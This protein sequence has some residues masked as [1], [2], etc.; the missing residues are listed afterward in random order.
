MTESLPPNTRDS[1][2]PVPDKDSKAPLWRALITIVVLALATV[3]AFSLITTQP[4]EPV[5]APADEFSAARMMQTLDKMA[6][7]G[8]PRPVGS[9][10]NARVRAQ[11]IGEIKA[12]GYKPTI[13]STQLTTQAVFPTKAIPVVVRQDISPLETMNTENIRARAG[14]RSRPRTSAI[15]R[16][17]LRHG[18][19]RSW[20]SRRRPLGRVDG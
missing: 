18:A 20:R 15:D 7:T 11:L 14:H 5:D 1:E 12:L 8:L 9:K 17:P 13:Q 2:D 10:E 19:F 6:A 3:Y 4:P 16:W